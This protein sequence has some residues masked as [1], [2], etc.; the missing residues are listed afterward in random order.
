MRLESVCK[1]WQQLALTSWY[2]VRSIPCESTPTELPIQPEYFRGLL[3]K[4][5][6][7]CQSI[8]IGCVDVARVK[9]EG[10]GRF[11]LRNK[12]KWLLDVMAENCPTLNSLFIPTAAFLDEDLRMI[13]TTFKRLKNLC[14]EKVGR[15]PE[16][17]L[18][19]EAFAEVPET[20]EE[21]RMHFAQSSPCVNDATLHYIADRAQMNLKY[22]KL[23]SDWD[24]FSGEQALSYLLTRCL[25]LTTVKLG[26]LGHE[27]GESLTTACLENLGQLRYRTKSFDI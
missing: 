14:L 24:S 16:G 25:N 18:S 22:F 3:R 12:L 15:T 20:L 13:F 6:P 21:I 4:C 11:R 7:F 9:L 23:C 8:D 17:Q 27:A 1:K 10:L 19:G 5:G 26:C 2:R